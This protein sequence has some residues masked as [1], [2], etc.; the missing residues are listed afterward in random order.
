MS[1]GSHLHVR[2]EVRA[3]QCAAIGHGD[4]VSRLLSLHGS[5]VQF[6]LLGNVAGLFSLL[7]V[8]LEA[9]SPC[10]EVLSLDLIFDGFQ[11]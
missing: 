4:S 9:N 2:V 8:V 1:L 5:A 6:L 7:L 11:R 3:C 10:D